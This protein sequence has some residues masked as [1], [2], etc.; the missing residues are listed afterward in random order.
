MDYIVDDDWD[1]SCPDEPEFAFLGKKVI[2]ELDISRALEQM[3]E[4]TFEDAELD[5]HPVD[6]TALMEAVDAF[7]AKYKLTYYEHDYK[8]KVRVR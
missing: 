6:M 1:M 5:I 2:K 3:T 7:N 8:R 4:D